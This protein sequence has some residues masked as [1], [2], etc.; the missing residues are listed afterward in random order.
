MIHLKNICRI[1]LITGSAFLSSVSVQGQ[2]LPMPEL[3]RIMIRN[4]LSAQ[5]Q[6][7]ASGRSGAERVKGQSTYDNV[8]NSFADSI[9]LSYGPGGTSAFDLSSMLFP[10]NNQHLNAPSFEYTG[11]FIN[12]QV[13]YKNLRRQTIDP[14]TLTYGLYQW[15]GAQYD[16]SGN[17]LRDTIWYAD[18]LS[19]PNRIY[20]QVFNASNRIVRAYA[21]NWKS[22]K[23]DSVTKRFF[24]YDVQNRLISDSVYQFSGGN[25][26][27][28]SRTVY[29]YSTGV[30][31]YR[32]NHF[33]NYFDTTFTKPLKEVLR[34]ENGFDGS[35]RLLTVRTSYYDGS[36]LKPY[37]LDTFSYTG[38]LNFHTSWR[39]YQFEPINNRWVPQFRMSKQLNA[40]QLP[41][42]IWHDLYDSTARKWIPYIRYNMTY[43]ANGNP[44]RKDE[45]DH[46]MVSFPATP[47]FTTRY[48]YEAISTTSIALTMAEVGE[49]KSWPNPFRGELNMEIPSDKDYPAEDLQ[50][51]VMD[52]QGREMKCV[53]Q[54][55]T[56]NLFLKGAFT[57]G[58]YFFTI[59]FHRE[60][61]GQGRI[62]AVE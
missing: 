3:H 40:S 24:K 44:V 18:S 47:N 62:I 30:A 17:L 43:N 33:T 13:T 10:Y 7:S 11:N 1:G 2:N 32:I 20:A 14:N 54:Y 60:L 48:Y 29:T 21:N 56:G 25:W 50:M 57:P 5:V 49:W 12:P 37:V 8:Q 55:S 23:S 26:Y 38:S 6:T 31:P 22:G 16:P 4:L 27:K 51:I 34:Y 28:I 39:E 36:I 46:N 35:G 59:T 61:V 58:V 19:Q 42:L 45:Y 41:D 52:M 15:E 9:L 53:V